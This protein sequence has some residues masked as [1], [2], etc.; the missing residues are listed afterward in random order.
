MKTFLLPHLICPTCLPKEHRL[1]LTA[2]RQTGD[3]IIDGSLRCAGCGRRFPIE[4]GVAL[5][6]PGA[7]NEGHWRYEDAETL[8]RYLWSHYADLHGDAGN[9]AAVAAWAGALGTA[10]TLALDAGCS[11]GRIV[12]ELAA[13][14]ATAVGCDLSLSFVKTA[15]RLARER[16]LKYSLPLEGNLRETFEIVLPDAL[17][18]DRVE[19]VVADAL[20]LPFAK[21]SFGQVSSLNVLDRV[22]YPLAHLYEMNRVAR[23]RDARFLFASPF[24][25]TSSDIPEERWLGGTATGPYAG[26]GI[27]NVRALLEGKGKVLAP[28]WR[29]AEAVSVQWHMRSHRNHCETFTSETLLALR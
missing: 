14:G 6:L 21:G 29:S 9:A 11:V 16:R 24:S 8:N 3:D 28:P 22:G 4:D 10:G 25:W 18:S 1:E 23:E 19:F 17:P 26:R 2:H 15:R 5:L 12:L 7:E 13:A 27:D 20:R